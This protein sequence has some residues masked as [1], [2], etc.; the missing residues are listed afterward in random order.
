MKSDC[1]QTLLLLLLLGIGMAGCGGNAEPKLAEVTGKV[2]YKN[3]PLP[4]GMVVFLSDDGK[5]GVGAIQKNGTFKM[6]S[7]FGTVKAA[8]VTRNATKE[9]L[10]DG[11][12]PAVKEVHMPSGV[13]P[14]TL[15]S[16]EFEYFE[17]SGLSFDVTQNGQ[18]IDI[19]LPAK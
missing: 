7:P 8:V 11:K 1:R 15:P 2:T 9:S 13:N 5:R 18:T 16:R 19:K 14:E 12:R 10:K 17:T 3:K 6:K 4:G